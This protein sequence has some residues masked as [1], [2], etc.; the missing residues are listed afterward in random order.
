M[1]IP[2]ILCLVIIMYPDLRNTINPWCP[3][4]LASSAK[5]RDWKRARRSTR[6]INVC[7]SVS[8]IRAGC[9]SASNLIGQYVTTPTNF[10]VKKRHT[11]TLRSSVFRARACVN[12][13]VVAISESEHQAVPQRGY[14]QHT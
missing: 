2:I 1:V 9:N 12:S 14:P 13:A 7:A 5:E 10:H 4:P 6:N 3:P 8:K 11:F